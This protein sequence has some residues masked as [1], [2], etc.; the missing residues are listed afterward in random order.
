MKNEFARWKKLSQKQ[1]KN[2]PKTTSKTNGKFIK[3]QCQ[4]RSQKSL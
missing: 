3:N 1:K 2:Y 4:K